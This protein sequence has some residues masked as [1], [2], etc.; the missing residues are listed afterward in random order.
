MDRHFRRLLS[1]PYHRAQAELIYRRGEDEVDEQ[2]RQREFL[3][4]QHDDHGEDQ[5]DQL[6]EVLAASQ[7]A[8]DVRDSG[9]ATPSARPARHV[10]TGTT[11]IVAA[12]RCRPNSCVASGIATSD[13]SSSD[14]MAMANDAMAPAAIGVGS[15]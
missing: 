11:I 4:R 3:E 6:G 1:V 9:C 14:G 15:P 10:M 13:S 8:G 5:L 7:F 2:Q 12:I